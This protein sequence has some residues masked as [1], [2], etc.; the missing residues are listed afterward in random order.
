MNYCKYNDWTVEEI[1]YNL[2]TSDEKLRVLD[3]V[4]KSWREWYLSKND[5]NMKNEDRNRRVC[6]IF[7]SLPDKEFINKNPDQIFQSVREMFPGEYL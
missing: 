5:P 3:S 4:S 2:E 1:F 7:K 6:E